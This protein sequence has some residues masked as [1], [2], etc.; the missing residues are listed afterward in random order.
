MPGQKVY[1]PAFD[2]LRAIAMLLV[3]AAH[4]GVVAGTVGTIGLTLFFVLSGF[5]IT[6][7]LLMEQ[8]VRGRIESGT[9]SSTLMPGN[10]SAE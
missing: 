8:E 1:F 2:S 4:A 5:L 6:Y 10:S 9:S 3:F 7:L